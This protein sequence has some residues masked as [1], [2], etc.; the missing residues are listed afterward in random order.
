MTG[1]GDG[2]FDPNGTLT[3]AQFY[4]M[5][6]RAVYGSEL[7][8]SSQPSNI[9]YSAAVR[10]LNQRKLLD[11]P[12]EYASYAPARDL[13][14]G[15]LGKGISRFEM[16]LLMYNIGMDNGANGRFGTSQ[17]NPPRDYVYFPPYYEKAIEW[18]YSKALLNGYDDG[19]FHGG[20]TVTR[21]QACAVVCRLHEYVN[22]LKASPEPMRDLVAEYN[23]AHDVKSNPELDTRVA[24]ETANI[25]A[26]FGITDASSDFEKA[27]AVY[28]YITSNYTYNSKKDVY[29]LEDAIDR[30][31]G[32]CDL[33][34]SLMTACCRELGLYC[35]DFDGNASGAGHQWN[36]VYIDGQ[37]YQ[38]DPTWDLGS[39]PKDFAY[40]LIS[41]ELMYTN[42]TPKWIR[43]GMYGHYSKD[44]YSAEACYA[45]SHPD[46]PWAVRFAVDGK[47]GTISEDITITEKKDGIFYGTCTVRRTNKMIGNAYVIKQTINGV[48]YESTGIST[49]SSWDGGMDV[50]VEIEDQS[51]FKTFSSSTIIPAD[52]TGTG[53]TQITVYVTVNGERH[54]L[55]IADISIV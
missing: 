17:G 42:H 21:A 4:V 16:A 34:A 55:L 41:D 2:K 18:C 39:E 27:Y 23:D 22:Q 40:F 43:V 49:L 52:A 26:Q 20:D 50:S 10:L 46:V 54:T 15:G 19:A 5:M 44:M 29:K 32:V 11:Y 14:D 48:E 1:V 9:W 31:T 30:K 33:I 8:D 36:I 7:D 28:R 25:K 51:L 45:D 38:C 3:C 24:A 35:Y 37:W 47:T 53:T 13:S 6:A 12:A